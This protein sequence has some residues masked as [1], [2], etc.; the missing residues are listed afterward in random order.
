LAVGIGLLVLATIPLVYGTLNLLAPA[1]TIRWQ[2]RA[3]ERSKG[4]RREIGQVF[5]RAFEA[6][7]DKTPWDDP[8]VRRRVRL[9]GMF[10]LALGAATLSGGIFLIVTA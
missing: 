4:A 10:L 9:V 8:T 1:V 2:V 7:P 5:Q 3:T 6:D